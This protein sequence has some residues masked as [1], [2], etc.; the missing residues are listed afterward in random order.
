MAWVGAFGKRE[1][2]RGRAE[3]IIENGYDFGM[4]EHKFLPDCKNATGY[5][6]MGRYKEMVRSIITL[7]VCFLETLSG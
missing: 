6:K 2:Q 4:F 3:E 7:A 1:K 5:V